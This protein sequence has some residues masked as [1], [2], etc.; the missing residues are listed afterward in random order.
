MKNLA[1]LATGFHWLLN[2]PFDQVFGLCK[3]HRPAAVCKMLVTVTFSFSNACGRH[4]S[5]SSFRH[6]DMP[7]PAR[8]PCRLMTWTTISSPGRAIGFIAFASSLI[9]STSTPWKLATLFRLEIYGKNL[10]AKLLRH[11]QSVVIRNRNRLP[12]SRS[13]SGTAAPSVSC[14]NVEPAPSLFLSADPANPLYA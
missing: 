3:Y 12:Q 1:F 9:F 7:H 6:R 14:S 2:F 13:A 5:L 11:F 10:S 8:F 4:L